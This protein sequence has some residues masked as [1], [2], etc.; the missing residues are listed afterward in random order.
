MP[1]LYVTSAL[2]IPDGIEEKRPAVIQVS[3]HGFAA[4]RSRGN[5]RMIYNLVRKGF[6]V[7]AI[8]PLGQGE[9]VQYWDPDKKSSMMGRSPT[10]EHSYFGN[11]MFL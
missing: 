10:S 7:L 11:Q 2:F 4:F 9:R 8:D 1:N 5:Q 6:I 3:G